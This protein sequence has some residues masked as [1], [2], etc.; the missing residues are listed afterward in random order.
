MS[1]FIPK[2]EYGITPT[3]ITFEYPP[4]GSDPF[5]KSIRTKSQVGESA[6]GKTQTSFLANIETYDLEFA[7]VKKSIIDELETFFLQHAS[8][9][10]SFKYFFD[11]DSASFIT[12][13][14]DKSSR[15]FEPKASHFSAA[16]NDFKYNFKMKLRIV[17]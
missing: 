1:N 4:E 10:L 7:F 9:G 12:V 11:K 6:S 15:K 5:G 2:I 16:D 3:T 13:E 14:L 17:I 8:R